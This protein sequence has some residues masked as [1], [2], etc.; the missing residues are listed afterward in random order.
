MEDLRR[1]ASPEGVIAADSLFRY[2]RHLMVLSLAALVALFGGWHR[3]L[4]VDALAEGMRI[5]PVE[6]D[7]YTAAYSAAE[8]D[9][10]FR[11][12]GPTGEATRSR[13]A[14]RPR[15]FITLQDAMREPQAPPPPPP[16][17]VTRQARSDVVVHTVAQ[18]ETVVG[19]ADHYQISVDTIRWANDL[20]DP[21]HILPGQKLSIL[22]VSG[23]MHEVREGDTLIDLAAAYRAEIKSI[24]LFNG[25]A[26]AD[27]L[28]IGQRL[29][30]PGGRMP[31]PVA[32]QAG[33]GAGRAAPPPT[34]LNL[35][36]VNLALQYQGS[37]Y[38]WG[39]TTPRGFDCSGFVMYVYRQKG[40]G[41]PR[42]TW[43]MIQ[44]G[45]PIG[46]DSLRPGDLVFFSTYAWG[47]SHVG[48]YIG[49]GQ[50]VHASDENTGVTVS[51]LNSS[52]WSSAYYAARRI[53]T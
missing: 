8:E 45:T 9:P 52:F 17:E 22:P 24:L 6:E 29:I 35:Q 7:L 10:A 36:I 40:I 20:D 47:P 50:F 18:G 2:S 13:V 23:V 21:D 19:I 41:L 38:M 27:H 51:S 28:V 4:D 16:D 43:G 39:G 49:G 37:P 42:D 14:I 5:A 34:P 31:D 15:F 44:T 32:V 48:I 26:D 11:A 3:S 25:I 53:N 12:A 1:T 30:V 33:G 46:R